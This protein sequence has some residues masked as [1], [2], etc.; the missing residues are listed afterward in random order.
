MTEP[1][2]AYVA[3]LA[4]LDQDGKLEMAEVKRQEIEYWDYWREVPDAAGQP[5]TQ[6]LFVEMDKQNGWFQLWKG[7]D[8]DPQRV[9]VI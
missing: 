1:Y 6:Y 2:R 8:M 3:V 4:D 5:T 9:L 7:E